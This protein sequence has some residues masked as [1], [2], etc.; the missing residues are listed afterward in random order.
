MVGYHVIWKD[1]PNSAADDVK[2]LPSNVRKDLYT[3]SKEVLVDFPDPTLIDDEQ[4]LD[5]ENGTM[6]RRAA[7]REDMQALAPLEDGAAITPLTVNFL[8]IYRSFN[9]TEISQNR[10]RRG[11][12]VSR[13]IENQHLAWLLHKAQST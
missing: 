13:I 11:Y 2:D 8:Y 7:R 5:A 6:W 12:F 1:G 4:V 10:G 3:L 9:A